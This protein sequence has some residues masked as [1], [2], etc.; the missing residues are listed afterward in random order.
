MALKGLPGSMR[1]TGAPVGSSFKE[2]LGQPARHPPAESSTTRVPRGDRCEV[3]E[4]AAPKRMP[5][6]DAHICT[7]YGT[8]RGVHP[9]PAMP[10]HASAM[11]LSLPC[12]VPSMGDPYICEGAAMLSHSSVDARMAASRCTAASHG[13][14]GPEA[15]FDDASLLSH[16]CIIMESPGVGGSN[17]INNIPNFSTTPSF[18]DTRL[19]QVQICPVGV[20]PPNEG[21]D[22]GCQPYNMP[23]SKTF[24]PHNFQGTKKIGGT[25]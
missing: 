5:D 16:D 19:N 17:I 9:Q 7:V 10:T 14:R 25:S 11:P 13:C 22:R 2:N 1:E 4:V 3:G 18:L 24:N 23:F 12:I 8:P 6:I 21:G 15:R 20:R